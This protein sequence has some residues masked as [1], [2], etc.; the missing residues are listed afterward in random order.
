M[1]AVTK[2]KRPAGRTFY[3]TVLALSVLAALSFLS[4]R[5][6]GDGSS[7]RLVGRS[8]VRRDEEV[9]YNISSHS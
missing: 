4:H 3:T 9:R 6:E 7:N 1:N 5:G 8:L 2:C